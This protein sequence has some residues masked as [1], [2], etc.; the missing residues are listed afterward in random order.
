MK[1]VTFH[2]PSFLRRVRIHGGEFDSS[3]RAM[4]REKQ[5]R[6]LQADLRIVRGSTIERKQMSTTIKRVALV[7][8]AALG[9][10][11]LSVAPS[12][13]VLQAD[14]LAISATTAAI[15]TG[16]TATATLTG[17]FLSGPSNAVDTLTVVASATSIPAGGNVMPTLVASDTVNASVNVNGLTAT[18]V[19]LAQT[20][21]TATSG[22]ITVNVVMPAA[23]K[24]GVYA[25]KFTPAVSAGSSLNSAA[26]FFT[27]TVTA[28][29]ADDLVVSA[30]KSTSV[31]STGETATAQIADSATVVAKTLAPTAQ[32][33][34]IKVVLKNAADK[35]LA[36]ASLTVI[37][38]SGTPGT[39]GSS[40][41]GVS[42]GMTSQGRAISTTAG[43]VIGVFS[44]GT[45][46]VAEVEIYAGTILLATEK[47]TFF[48]DVASYAGT[49]AVKSLGVGDTSTITVTGKDKA[50][51]AT[52]APT[53]YATS[54]D[55]SVA[56]VPA[57]SGSGA[58][59]VT[60]V[61]SGKATITLCDT[62][63][64]ASA[65][66][67]ST[68]AI[69]VGAKTAKTVTLS[70]SPAA[71]TAGE[72]V[73]VTLTAT[74]AS[75]NPVADGAR[76]LVSSAGFT[77][78]VSVSGSTLPT[79]ET[80]TIAA[81][82]VDYIFYAPAAGTVTFTATEGSATDSTTKGTITGSVTVANPGLD[83]A[84]DAANEAIDAA[85]AATDAALAAA[86]AADAATTAAQEASDAVAALSESVTK[87]IAGLQAQIKSL[88]A[89]VAKIAKK[90]KA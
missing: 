10:G 73:T 34:T 6:L 19:N 4:N 23:A 58:I 25:Y 81:G 89:V 2:L 66:I 64:C 12:Q 36:D 53:I 44:D 47:V 51:N 46:G 13:A 38:K 29:P 84:T 5:V 15:Q 48:G 71:P 40:A 41:A 63:A 49:F 59:V 3:A 57:T 43:D 30:A 14:T 11:V 8:V 74:D 56:T 76:F 50:G 90:V 55:T 67:T 28:A 39:V 42:S 82:V 87:L 80:V 83:A 16:E 77:S 45:E 33:A 54:S 60:G 52:G 22:K 88:A 18:I 61:K 69:T 65:K 1:H 21:A 26:V 72:K 68:V 62:A 70:F 27:V 9:L 20:A 7:A 78:S 24:P 85:N 37:V 31:I 79:G 35:T 75:G 32:A 17:T 86:E